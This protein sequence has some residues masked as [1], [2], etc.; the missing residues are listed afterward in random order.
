M[1]EKQGGV[2]WSALE[3][4]VDIVLGVR[5]DSSGLDALDSGLDHRKA[6]VRILPRHVLEVPAVERQASEAEAGAE[7]DVGALAC[8]L[9][10]H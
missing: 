7:L 1:G 2:G 4:H 10:A 3:S 6:E 5:D 8:E 9:G